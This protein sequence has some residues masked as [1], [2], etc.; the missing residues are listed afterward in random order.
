MRVGTVFSVASQSSMNDIFKPVWN[1][2]TVSFKHKQKSWFAEADGSISTKVFPPNVQLPTA[3]IFSVTTD[4]QDHICIQSTMYNTYIQVSSGNNY[5]V[6]GNSPTPFQVCIKAALRAPN[7]K[8]LDVNPHS[9]CIQPSS[10]RLVDESSMHFIQVEKLNGICSISSLVNQRKLFWTVNANGDATPSSNVCGPAHQFTL[11]F[12]R[13]KYITIQ[14][15]QHCF[16]SPSSQ[17]TIQFTQT[18]SQ[19]ELLPYLKS[20]K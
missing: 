19:F 18:P 13:P 7:N 16:A 4:D 20:P 1:K 10:Y 11:H 8:F 9:L 3:C 17:N 5:L 15:S 14:N 2:D 12:P 6:L